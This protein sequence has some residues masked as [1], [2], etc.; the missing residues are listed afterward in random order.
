MYAFSTDYN[1]PYDKVRFL[2]T[3]NTFNINY[4]RTEIRVSVN[5]NTEST[6]MMLTTVENIVNALGA[7]EYR[8]HGIDNYGDKTHNHHKA[9]ENQFHHSSW[10]GTTEI[11]KRNMY[12]NSKR[13]EGK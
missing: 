9:Y 4:M 3:K 13:Y 7:H 1:T 5:Q 11:F 10:W 8:G 2:S 6:K 12:I